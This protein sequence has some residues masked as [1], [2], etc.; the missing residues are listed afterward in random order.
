[1]PFLFH[2][3]AGLR[4]LLLDLNVGVEKKSGKLASI[5]VAVIAV[6]LFILAGIYVW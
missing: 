3:V 2:L 1:L 6:L 4:H 5:V